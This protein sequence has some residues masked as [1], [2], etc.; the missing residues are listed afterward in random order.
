VKQPGSWAGNWL[1]Y[2]QARLLLQKSDGESL[3]SARDVAMISILL[4][5]GLRR[6]ELAS[7]RKED[8]QIWQGYWAIVDLVGKGGHICTVPMPVWVKSAVDRWMAAAA[9]TDGRVFRAYAT[10]LAPPSQSV[11]SGWVWLAT[12]STVCSSSQEV[13]DTTA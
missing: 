11:I 4:V 9:V 5:C 2:D 7:L 12:G 10:G 6:A 3:R 1:N 8:V 13:R